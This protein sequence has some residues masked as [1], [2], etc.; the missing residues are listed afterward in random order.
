MIRVGNRDVEDF[1]TAAEVNLYSDAIVGGVLH[2][3]VVAAEAEGDRYEVEFRDPVAGVSIWISR[4]P[5]GRGVNVKAF[6]LIHPGGDPRNPLREDRSG[7][8]S[9]QLRRRG[10]GCR[11]L[12]LLLQ[13]RGAVMSGLGRFRCSQCGGSHGG[14]CHLSALIEQAR[15]RIYSV[16]PPQPERNAEIRRRR[17][18][19]ESCRSLALA[20][21]L[22]VPRI[23]QITKAAR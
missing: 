14:A 11:G 16:I 13:G 22:S 5:S 18:A 2:D 12:R 3:T 8:L 20:F 23:S 15:G 19:G 1:T 4:D 9:F 7:I 6:F 10:R 17:A 21:G